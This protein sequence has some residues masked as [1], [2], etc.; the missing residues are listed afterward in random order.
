MDEKERKIKKL[1]EALKER[2]VDTPLLEKELLPH[3]GEEV[4][5]KTRK[6]KN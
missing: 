3:T 6:K 2:G 5:L 4:K 1:I